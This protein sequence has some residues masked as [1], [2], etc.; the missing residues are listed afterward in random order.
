MPVPTA[1]VFRRDVIRPKLAGGDDGSEPR[2]LRQR[3]ELNETVRLDP[4]FLQARVDLAEALL[5]AS[6]AKTALSILDAAPDQQ[7][8]ILALVTQRNWALLALDNDPEARNWVNRGLKVARA[9]DLLT[10]ESANE[11]LK[12]N[13]G[14]LRALRVLA[15]SYVAQ[16]Q[17]AAALRVLQEQ[18]AQHPKSAATQQ[19]LGEWLLARGE[20]A[21]ARA[22]LTAAKTANPNS[23]DLDMALTQ[24]DV[25]EGKLDEARKTL[26]GILS[27]N[28]ANPEAHLWLGTIEVKTGNYGPAIEQFR[29]VLELDETNVQALNNLA[30]LL[31]N[32][33]NHP[34]EALTLAQR[35]RELA[36]DDVDTEGTLGWV[37]Y[38]KALYDIARK[39]LQE[40]VTKDGESSTQNAAIRKYHLALDYLKLGDRENIETWTAAFNQLL[41][42]TR[43]N[44]Q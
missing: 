32:F 11:V 41:I 29:K 25:S 27:S 34:D 39:Y 24:L 16:K 19:F 5:E 22:A 26:K 38:R 6:S 4:Q 10:Q 30:Y 23:A 2:L 31:A 7:K 21:Q 17:P 3:M 37:L 44:L 28:V 43:P 35:A 14:D 13:P 8:R 33:A 15:A 1:S 20:L 12:K 42:L 18:A 9:P 36:P 40:P